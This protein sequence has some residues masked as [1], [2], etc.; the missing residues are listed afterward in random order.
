MSNYHKWGD[1]THL[2]GDAGRLWGDPIDPATDP[3]LYWMIEVDWTNSGTY[4]GDNEAAYCIDLETNAGRPNRLNIDGNGNADGIKMPVVGTARITLDNTSKRFDPYY[5]AG[6]LYG[7]IIPGRY[8]RI[9]VKYHDVIYP[10]FHG[11]ITKIT[12]D[13]N[14]DNPI[15]YIDCENGMRLLQQADVNVAIQTDVY[16]RNAVWKILQDMNWP[17][18]FGTELTGSELPADETFGT[19]FI[20]PYFSANGSAKERLQELMNS[21]CGN[22]FVDENGLARF[23]HFGL[24]AGGVVS[25]EIAEENT[26]K[27]MDISSPWEN[28]INTWKL[29]YYPPIRQATGT[30]WEYGDN[31]SS[32]ANGASIDV[33][34]EYTFN[35]SPCSA[36]GVISPA[37]TTDYTMFANSDGTGT[38]LTGSFTVVQTNYGDKSKLVITNSSGSTGYIT[39]LK[40][41]GDALT[42]DNPSYYRNT[43]TASINSYGIRTI[44]LKSPYSQVYKNAFRIYTTFLRFLVAGEVLYNVQMEGRPDQQ[45]DTGIFKAIYLLLPSYGIDPH[46]AKIIAHTNHKWLTPNGQAVRTTIL[47]EDAY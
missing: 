1:P 43:H 11:N 10:I 14:V 31:V 6:A 47:L 3:I 37:A 40:I 2:W 28:I 4:T 42:S 39:L 35:S 5:A 36:L 9:R 21:Y 33:W 8:I 38:N 29:F 23:T 12:P 32:I 41:R 44:T 16:M 13:N 24:Y 19:D 45:F 17:M 7:R 46:Q 15:V 34:A 18:R 25:F 26:L 20:I 22:F 27:D 30:I